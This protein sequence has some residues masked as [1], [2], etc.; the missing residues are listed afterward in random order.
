MREKTDNKRKGAASGRTAGTKRVSGGRSTAG[1]T[2]ASGAGS[3]STGRGTRQTERKTGTKCAAGT[4][5]PAAGTRK[6]AAAGRKAPAAKPAQVQAFA[7]FPER[8]DILIGRNPVTEALK[9]ERPVEKLIV[10]D[11]AGGSLGRIVALAK[12]RGV[13]VE[14]VDKK[15]IE[16]LVGTAP[17]QGVVAITAAHEYAELEDIFALARASGE[18]PFI[19]ILDGIEDP[20]N[21]GAIMRTAECAGAHGVIIPK[22]RAAGITF[23]AAKAAA[24]AVEYIPCVRVANIAQTIDELKDRGVWIYACDMDGEPYNKTKLTGPI[25]LVVGNEGNGISR[26]VK[27]KCDFVV[28][29]PMYGKIDSLNASNAAAILMYEIRRQ[30]EE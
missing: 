13:I 18:Y 14:T 1:G 12:D 9:S 3:R 10:Q 29:I 19:I 4:G 25:G 5:K 27:E 17:H 26:L 2:R 8:D 20:H 22:R 21:L 6:T 16:R 7:E 28:S 23:S 24:G 15:A 30:R 11:G